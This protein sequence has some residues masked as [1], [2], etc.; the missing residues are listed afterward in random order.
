MKKSFSCLSI[1]LILAGCT[2]ENV[3]GLDVHSPSSVAYY[4]RTCI[5]EGATPGSPSMA[6][7]VAYHSQGTKL[8]LE[9]RKNGRALADWEIGVCIAHKDPMVSIY[10]RCIKSGV[11]FGSAEMGPCIKRGRA[12][13]ADLIRH[14]L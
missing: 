7:C 14:G 9:C 11:K 2:T 6:T 3:D 13:E 4:K 8:Y 10:R 5:Q 1:I 12:K